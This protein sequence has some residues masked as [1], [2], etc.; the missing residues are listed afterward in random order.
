MIP[1]RHID[2]S[3]TGL[4]RR[5]LNNLTHG[6]HWYYT[7]R[8]NADRLLS[9]IEHVEMQFATNATP[10]EREYH[11]R[12]YDRASAFL[13]LWPSFT[14]PVFYWWLM[15]TDGDHSEP[16]PPSPLKDARGK[17]HQRLIVPGDYE[18]V[19]RPAPGGLPRRTWQ[20]TTASYEAQA[21]R[22]R[23]VIRRS[24]GPARVLHLIRKFNTFPAFRGVR[25]QVASLRKLALADWR[26]IK[27][28]SE[29]LVLPPFPPYIRYKHYRTIEVQIVIDRCRAGTKP[30][31]Q[32]DRR[33]AAPLKSE[34]D[35]HGSDPLD[36]DEDDTGFNK[37]QTSEFRISK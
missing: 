14:E 6:Y 19:L 10:K 8:I 3:K 5:L 34:I 25:T 4:M 24:S 9:F 21:D 33:L 32:E 35:D 30:F 22:I 2:V 37:N 20:L 16:V 13:Y 12:R 1:S 7:G 29:Q 27:S 18:A 36:N 11:R 23:D 28:E 17:G 15:L 26:R 31:T